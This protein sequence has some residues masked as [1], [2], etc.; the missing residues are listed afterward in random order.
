MEVTNT[1]SQVLL[2]LCFSLLAGSFILLL[3]PNDY[4]PDVSIKKRFL[5]IS[6]VGVPIF[7]FVPIFD[8]ALYLAPRLGLVESFKMV[9]TSFTVGTT[10][11]FTLLGSVILVLLILFAKPEEQGIFALLGIALSFG[12][13]LTVAWSSHAGTVNLVLGITS[14]FIHL[15]AVSVWVGIILVIGWSSLN[16]KNWLKFLR[17]FS[18]VAIGCFM[19]T[20]IS[21]L[22]LTDIMVDDYMDSWR[23]SYGQGLLI[24]HLFL[25]PLVFYAFVNGVIV[26]SFVSKFANYKPIPW[27]RV[28]GMILLVILTVTAIFSQAPPPH[29]NY[30][31][32]EVVSPLFRLFHGDIMD[33][34]STLAFAGNLNTV[35]FLI[36][37]IILLGLMGWAFF[38]KAPIFVSFLLSSLFVISIYLMLMVSV[39]VR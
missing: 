28:E 16:D 2:Y 30:M 36:L 14:D 12:L 27:V 24:K 29:G 38:K 17:W 5:L 23:V 11:N 20:A 35:Y 4:R 37:S 21:G 10:W 26:K 31:T 39:V 6:A 9:L 18:M 25:L 13:I 7:S 22:L 32:N 3:V 34:G 1:I 8:L 33:L 15:A 19:I